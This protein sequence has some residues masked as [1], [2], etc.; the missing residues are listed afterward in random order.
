M[1]NYCKTISG[2]R[3]KERITNFMLQFKYF[4]NYPIIIKYFFFKCKL[5]TNA[6]TINFITKFHYFSE[7]FEIFFKPFFCIILF[8]VI[9]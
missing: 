1:E 7:Q 4:T 6:N 8:S 3:T 9:L 2:W 5:N